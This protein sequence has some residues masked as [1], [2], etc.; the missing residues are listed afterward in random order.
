MKNEKIIE[1][2]ML[3]TVTF[4]FRFLSFDLGIA[5]LTIFRFFLIIALFSLIVN[6]RTITICRQKKIE[7]NII[8]IFF[9]MSTFTIVFAIDFAS[10]I[11]TEFFI[12]VALLIYILYINTTNSI[13]DI[14]FLLKAYNISILIQALIGVYEIVSHSYLFPH[15]DRVLASYLSYSITP[16]VGMLSNIN[17]YATLMLFGIV[18]NYIFIK[19]SYK[20]EIL[21]YLLTILYSALI[22]LTGSRGCILGMLLFYGVLYFSFIRGVTKKVISGIVILGSMFFF[23]DYLIKVLRFD[24]AATANSDST[25]INLIKNGILFLK[26]TFGFGIG[27]G[28]ENYWLA[29]KMVYPTWGITAFHNLWIEIAACFGL[30]LLILFV[31]SLLKYAKLFYKTSFSDNLQT[32]AVSSGFFLFLVELT[33]AS[34]SSSS[35]IKSEYFWAFFAIMSAYYC[36]LVGDIKR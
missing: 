3:T 14:C 10:W 21:Y 1:F 32:R 27:A 19:N 36:V 28:Q 13:D 25:R 20:N 23:K 33:I 18:I 7:C 31:Y 15:E 12:L 5:Q 35:L 2:L 24:F 16:P 8:H 17:D 29:N 4:G 22:M 6:K 34:V 9:A 11:R 26:Q 30:A